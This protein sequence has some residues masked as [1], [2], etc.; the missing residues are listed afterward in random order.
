MCNITIKEQKKNYLTPTNKQK[1][2]HHHIQIKGKKEVR[3][4]QQQQK[5]KKEINHQRE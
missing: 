1:V 5:I 3:R 4:K 2:N